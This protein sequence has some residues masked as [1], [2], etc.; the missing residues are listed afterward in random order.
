VVGGR[1]GSTLIHQQADIRP[2][3]VPV[4][5]FG[6]RQALL[7]LFLSGLRIIMMVT[8]EVTREGDSQSN[9]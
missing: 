5:L 6:R 9:R 1:L 8:K 7:M 2:R 4:T 3:L